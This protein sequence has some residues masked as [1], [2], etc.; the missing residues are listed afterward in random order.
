MI[1]NPGFTLPSLAA[2]FT[3]IQCRKGSSYL[4]DASPDRGSDRIS[5]TENAV[6]QALQEHAV[7]LGKRV[8]TGLIEPLTD[9]SDTTGYDGSTE[10]LLQHNPGCQET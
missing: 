6:W 5:I 9:G 3:V 1:Y 7:E 10:G 4:V 8:A 2:L